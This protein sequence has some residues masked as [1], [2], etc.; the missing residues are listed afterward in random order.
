[1]KKK[2]RKIIRRTVCMLVAFTFASVFAL[3]AEQGNA[4]PKDWETPEI[5]EVKQLV[6]RQEKV[7]ATECE[8]PAG[9]IIQKTEIIASNTV[10][11]GDSRT[12]AFIM[13]AGIKDVCALTAIGM[14]VE[15]ALN[16]E[17]INTAN[18]KCT[19]VD[20]LRQTDFDKV[21][22][23]L[24]INET[25]WVYESV[26]VNKYKELVDEIRLINPQ[27][28][29]Y[30]QSILPVSK[31]VSDTHQYIKN[32]KINRY[33]ELIQELAEEEGVYYLDIAEVMR[34]EDGALPDDAAPDGI[35][36]KKEYCMKWYEYIQS[37]SL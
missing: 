29:I 14:T 25:G 9:N 8:V 6:V 2:D 4:S 3:T 36:L 21:Y 12:E 11:I 13:Q 26:F 18:G 10:F 30:L 33:N 28:Q 1:M 22:I 34:D 19:V 5:Q 7:H 27:A 23:M 31:K 37:H 24:G 16:E 17:V 20:A 35:H 32:D 15:S